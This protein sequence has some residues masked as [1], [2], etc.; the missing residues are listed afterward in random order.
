MK[1]LPLA[2]PLALPLLLTTAVARMGGIN[3]DSR[4]NNKACREASHWTNALRAANN[5]GFHE[6]RLFGT[7][8]CGQLDKAIQA[9]LPLGIKIQV[10]VWLGAS[11]DAE[12]K[13]LIDALNKYSDHKWLHSVSVGSEELHR[14]EIDSPTL[15]AKITD[16]KGMLNGMGV[17]TMV[18]HVD[19]TD[20][21]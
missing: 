7:S 6:I 21:W 13:A 4:L 3:F 11:Y 20:G 14:H 10:G 16:V 2:L 15:A 12:K 18:G 5:A 19:A 17:Q 8:D 1:F 9:A